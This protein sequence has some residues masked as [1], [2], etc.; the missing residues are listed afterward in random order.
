MHV[1]SSLLAATAALAFLVPAGAAEAADYVALT[2]SG[3]L[4]VIDGAMWAHKSTSEIKGP[5]PI[6]GIDRRPADGM[7]YALM[8][9][10]GVATVDLMSGDVMMKGKLPQMPAAGSTVSV[11]F[12]PAAD[13]L[14]I[15]GSD[16]SN[17]RADVDKLTVT[18]D[19]PLMFATSDMHNGETPDIVAASYTNAM[20][21]TKETALYDIDATIDG[22][23]KQAPPNDGVLMAVGKLGAAVTRPAF[24]IQTDAAG[25]NW[26]WL[27]NG[28]EVHQLD[29]A[30]GKAK[31]IGMISGL[32]EA[33][34][35]IATPVPSVAPAS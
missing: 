27:V 13:K 25:N 34:V 2:E 4:A 15:I 1:R 3:K 11:D 21:G 26:A 33:V 8:A 29:L 12:N 23:I 10:G 6:V 22:L 35:D 31:P 20:K 7:L 30:T 19:K 5:S 24:D 14:R 9:D 28:T 32:D 16:G 17:L 18:Q